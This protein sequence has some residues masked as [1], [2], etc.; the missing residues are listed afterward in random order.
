MKPSGTTGRNRQNRVFSR[1]DKLFIATMVAVIL[2]A[3]WLQDQPRS[4]PSAPPAVS[5]VLAEPHP[6]PVPS[7]RTPE[8][9]SEGDQGLVRWDGTIMSPAYAACRRAWVENFTAATIPLPPNLAGLD[10][11]AQRREFAERHACLSMRTD[12]LRYVNS[13]QGLAGGPT[14]S[15]VSCPIRSDCGE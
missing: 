11:P 6:I 15:D 14:F 2:T 9:V 7:E 12:A 4:A 8:A 5:F 13:L 1:S 10:T 3:A